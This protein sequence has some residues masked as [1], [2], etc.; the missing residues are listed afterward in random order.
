M[1]V[2]CCSGGGGGGGGSGHD[3]TTSIT[4]IALLLSILVYLPIIIIS[5]RPL[6]H[7][8]LQNVTKCY[9]VLFISVTSAIDCY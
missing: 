8:V 7:I 1:A 5:R 6:R 3:I 4:N 9:S 2:M